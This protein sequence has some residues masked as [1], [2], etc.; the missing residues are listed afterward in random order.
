MRSSSSLAATCWGQ[1]ES[2]VAGLTEPDHFVVHRPDGTPIEQR[3]GAKRRSMW[4]NANGGSSWRESHRSE[5]LCLTEAQLA[6]LSELLGRV[7]DG[8][9]SRWRRCWREPAGVESEVEVAALL[10][11][12]Q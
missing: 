3:L 4:L 2:V 12:V 5:E 9:R 10:A 8:R 6:E 7:E 11:R 1:G